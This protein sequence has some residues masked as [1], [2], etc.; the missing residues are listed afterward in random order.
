MKSKLLL[1]LG[2]SFALTACSGDDTGETSLASTDE[3]TAELVSQE[4]QE[5]VETSEDVNESSSELEES[6]E[7][8]SEASLEET[9]EES[10]SQEA[11]E[12]SEPDES[13][14]PEQEARIK[15]ELLQPIA[16][17]EIGTSGS[18]L[19]TA[20]LAADW[21]NVLGEEQVLPGDLAQVTKAFVDQLEGQNQALFIESYIIISQT[22]E[23]LA[24][25]DEVTL[26]SLEDGGGFLN[27]NALAPQ[28]WSIYKTLLD[29]ILGVPADQPATY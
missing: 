12:L 29:E 19:K 27:D 11:E 23:N 17:L 16:D 3:V 25:G 22:A 21:L 7:S 18:S 8:G 5:E 20:N 13:I 10:V 4:E 14:T 2:L 15:A 24:R 9:S 26:A 28:A 6:Q 1:I